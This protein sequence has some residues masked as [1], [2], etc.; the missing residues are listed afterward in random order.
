MR[1]MNFRYW[2]FKVKVN[3]RSKNQKGQNHL[4]TETVLKPKNNVVV[5]RENSIVLTCVVAF[6]ADKKN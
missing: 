1:V 6:V 3:K 2:L 4:E 5:A